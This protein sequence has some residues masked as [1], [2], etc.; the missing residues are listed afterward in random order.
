MR[1]AIC[2]VS[3]ANIDLTDPEVRNIMKG[4]MKFN[5]DHD[6]TGILLYNE[7]NFF[8]LLEGEKQNIL[9][10]YKL[11]SEDSRHHDIIKFLEKPVF[12]PA[13]DGYLTEL[14]TDTK[15]C[16]ESTLEKYL[17]YIEVLSPESQKSIQRVMEL[18]MA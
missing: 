14:I 5:C 11:I 8:Q 15:K 16:D 1:Y 12:H 13:F 4:S 7:K 9:D 6:I 17:H 3:T 2:Y 18:M 10:L